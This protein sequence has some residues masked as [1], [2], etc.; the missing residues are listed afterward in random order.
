MRQHLTK[1]YLPTLEHRQNLEATSLRDVYLHI[2]I[3]LRVPVQEL[4]KHAFNVKG[5]SG[6]LQHTNIAA[7][8]I[9][10]TVANACCV[11]QQPSAIPEQL[12]A[13]TREA[14]AASHSI[15]QLDA[16]LLLKR[17]DLA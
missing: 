14:E 16:E 15:E 4:R 9:A 1:M 17:A 7:T 10:R 3:L 12:L 8:Q 2:G 5:R 11:I 13:L 6:D